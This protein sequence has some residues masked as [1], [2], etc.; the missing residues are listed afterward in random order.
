M[1][2]CVAAHAR[3]RCRIPSGGAGICKMRTNYNGRLMV[4][5]G[6]VAGFSADPIEKK[7]FFHVLPGSEA[8]SFGMLGC[9]LHCA[10]CQNWITSQSLRDPSADTTIQEVAAR[11]YRRGR[12]ARGH[13][14]FNLDLQRAAHHH[15][16]GRPRYSASGAKRTCAAASCR[17]A[18]PRRKPSISFVLTWIFSRWTLKCFRDENYRKLGVPP[19]GRH[20]DTLRAS[21]TQNF[22]SRLS[23]C[24]F[25]ASTTIPANCANSRNF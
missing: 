17:T 19:R 24:L 1:A 13:S 20:P 21:R 12:L 23:R 6:Y 5:W 15:G 2:P 16:M 18:R 8:L 14:N 7:P 25:P 10:F 11:E 3:T 9:N 22:G 4:P